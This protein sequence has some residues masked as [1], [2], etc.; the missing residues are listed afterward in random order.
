[1][2]LFLL[3]AALAGIFWSPDAHADCVNPAG[4]EAVFV[5]NTSY[6]TM[7]FCNGTHWIGMA[8]GVMPDLPGASMFDG[9]PDAIVCDVTNPAWGPVTLFPHHMPFTG[10]GKFV[11]RANQ[12][13]FSASH[14]ADGVAFNA[15]RTFESLDVTGDWVTTSC[16]GKSIAELYAAGKAFNFTGGGGGGSGG[17]AGWEDVPLTDTTNFDTQCDYR[18][19]A[20]GLGIYSDIVSTSFLFMRTNNGYITRIPATEKGFMDLYTEGTD[21]LT[22]DNATPVTN[23]QKNCGGGGSGVDTLAG[24]SCA[25]GEVVKWDG[26][27][28]ACAADGGGSGSSV[29]VDGTTAGDIFYDG[30]KVGIGTDDPLSV[31]Q[32]GTSEP[33]GLGSKNFLSLGSGHIWTANPNGALVLNSGTATGGL[34]GFWFRRPTAEADVSSFVDLV[35]ITAEGKVGIGTVNPAYNLHVIGGAYLA[36]PNGS[37]FYTERFDSDFDFFQAA[38]STK[39]AV[40]IHGANGAQ[41]PLEVYGNNGSFLLGLRVTSDGN[42]AT[43]G[44]GFKPGGGSWAATSDARLK[45]IDGD[46]DQ[47]LESIIKL[48]PVRFHYKKDNPRNEPSEKEYVGLIAQDAQKHFP[49]AV[50]TSSKDEYLSLDTTPIMFAVINAIKDLKS[51]NDK[52]RADLEAYKAAHP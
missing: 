50:F 10:S 15:D 14:K 44:N 38:G 48:K 16:D 27:V 8:G 41:A 29:W 37:Y 47:G 36:A 40:S 12:E 24:L 21:T 7:Q 52:L 19:V 4:E 33:V 30:G 51:E 34:S 45:N 28:W 9:W 46:Y 13:S 1:M 20:L 25:T 43:N 22:Q 5:Y 17:G 3:L 11:Y 18:A 42:I 39:R 49:E 32:V 23:L 2:R 31:L 35:R 26:T 6:K